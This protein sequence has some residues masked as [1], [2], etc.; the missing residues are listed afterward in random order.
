[1]NKKKPK[2]SLYHPSNW[3]LHI[4]LFLLRLLA[5][6]PRFVKKG[7]RSFLG[8]ALFHIPSQ[9]RKVAERNIRA[10][11]P[12]LSSIQQQQLLQENMRLMGAMLIEWLNMKWPCK[13]PLIPTIGTITGV[14][15]VEQALA[16]N[17]GVLLLFPHLIAIYLVGGLLL[18]K[19]NFSFGLM[20][21]S[22]KNAV[23]K[24]FFAT[25]IKQYCH[26]IFTR[27]DIRPMIQYLRQAKVVWY[28]PDLE[29]GKKHRVFAPFFNIPAATY[30][31][32][33]RIIELSGAAAIPIAFYR[34]DN[35]DVYDVIFQPP[36]TNFPEKD[37]V[38]NAT[39]LNK[40]TE[41]IIRVKPAQYLWIYKRFSKQPD[42]T[43][44]YD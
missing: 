16:E 22:P 18:N 32:T 3:P 34:R 27:K 40:M 36:L 14:E 8:W 31:T 37:E 24:R 25:T 5:Y 26:T 6:T 39:R 11:F 41:D 9:M 21:H 4:L 17:R 19:V 42:N 1:M 2:K 35:S 38:A 44:F 23:L 20:Y 12:E 7:L 30:T 29:P 13:H 33:A 43:S 15:H 10:C 28:A